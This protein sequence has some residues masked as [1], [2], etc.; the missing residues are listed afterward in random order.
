[1]TPALAAICK[2]VDSI[3][4]DWA[5]DFLIAYSMPLGCQ[6]TVGQL[7]AAARELGELEAVAECIQGIRGDVDDV[8]LIERLVNVQGYLRH[9]ECEAVP[10]GGPIEEGQRQC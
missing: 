8:T 3:P 7:R 9:G 10:L 4:A 1:M 6:I 2:L 5:D